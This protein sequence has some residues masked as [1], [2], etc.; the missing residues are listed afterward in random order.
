MI[1]FTRQSE[2]WCLQCTWDTLNTHSSAN[3]TNSTTGPYCEIDDLD[4]ITKYSNPTS[5]IVN[6]LC[7]YHTTDIYE[8]L[9]E[10]VCYQYACYAGPSLTCVKWTVYENG[11]LIKSDFVKQIKCTK[12]LIFSNFLQHL[13]V[14]SSELNV[15]LVIIFN[16][17]GWENGI[18]HL[19]GISF[20]VFLMPFSYKG[21]ITRAYQCVFESIFSFFYMIC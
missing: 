21:P 5:P 12:L 14:V 3:G 4:D 7:N 18:F 1:G 16:V 9:L 13:L 17:V 8:D 20:E 19:T 15:C 11:M 6:P 2:L 10:G